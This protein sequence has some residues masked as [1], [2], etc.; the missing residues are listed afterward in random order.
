M[1]DNFLITQGS[2]TTIAT[3]QNVDLSHEQKIQVTVLPVPVPVTDNAGSLTVDGTFFQATQ[4]ISAASL[5]L[6]TGA[7]LDATLTNG[8]TKVKITD[9]TEIALV[10]ATGALSV[11]IN[12]IGINALG[13][14]L[15]AASIPVVIASNQSIIPVSIPNPIQLLPAALAVTATGAAAAAVTLT[16]PAV[17]SKFHYISLI[18]IVAYSTVAR[19]GGVTPVLV[20]S[21]N[22]PGNPVWTFATAAAIGTTDTKLYVPADELKSSVINTA[23]TIV[24]PATA[25]VIWR[26]NVWYFTAV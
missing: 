18:E 9:G 23:T 26:I 5:P 6:P 16:L 25:S 10:S 19:T 13:Q 2:G 14:E 1:A 22:L 12:E 20:T 15:M 17:A 21:T 24:C 4:P 11:D 3:H 8:T 7:A